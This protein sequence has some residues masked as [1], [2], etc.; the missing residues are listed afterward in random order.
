MT[1]DEKLEATKASYPF[2]NW[3]KMFHPKYEDGID[4][5]EQY[6]PENCDKAE[7]I[8]DELISSLINAGETLP[9]K[10]KV[11]LFKT[12]VESLNSL[13]EEVHGLI[14]TGEREELCALFDEIATAAGLNPADYG[15]GEGIASEWREW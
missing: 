11:L 12:A 13:E 15:D 4:G 9:E 2:N 5:M 10:D 6:T 1:H 7:R 14:E 3:R 8:L